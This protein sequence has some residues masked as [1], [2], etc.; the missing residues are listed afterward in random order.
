MTYLDVT[1]FNELRDPIGLDKY[2]YLFLDDDYS[3]I[4]LGEFNLIYY[5]FLFI[6]FKLC[7]FILPLI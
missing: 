6:D 5:K 7:N 3:L 2:G 4:F 1:S